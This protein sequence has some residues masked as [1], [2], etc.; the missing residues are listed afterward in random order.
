VHRTPRTRVVDR[1]DALVELVRGRRVIDVGFADE[2]MMAAK[3]ARGAWLHEVVTEA[4]RECIGI[5]S[6][7][8]AVR[9]AQELGFT[10]H[11]AD[12]EDAAALRALAL[13]PAEVVLAGELIEHLDRPGAFIDAVAPLVAPEGALVLTTPNGHSLTNLLGALAGRELVNPDHVAWYSWRTLVTLLGRRGWS[14]DEL[15]YYPFPPVTSGS[16]APRLLFNGYQFAARPLFRARPA[17]ADGIIAVAR[18]S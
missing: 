1:L 6:D 10:A 5:D 17:L 8:D 4:A 12:V 16:R 18:R 7:E 11:V 9:R 2:G 15:S 3:R 14:I 13:E